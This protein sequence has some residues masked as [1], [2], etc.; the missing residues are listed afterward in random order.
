ML[1]PGARPLMTAPIA[2][3]SG[4]E[5]KSMVDLQIE[6]EIADTTVGRQ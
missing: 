5:V 1:V 2:G 4:D 6:I 3:R